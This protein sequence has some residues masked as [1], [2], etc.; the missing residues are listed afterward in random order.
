M[1]MERFKGKYRIPSAR[2]PNWNYAW[3]A[4]YFIT[5]CTKDRQPFFGVIQKGVMQLSSIGKIVEAEWL[6]TVALRSDMNIELGAY[7][8]MPNH[9]HAI[10]IIGENQFN[11]PR[12]DALRASRKDLPHASPKDLPRTSPTDNVGKRD[13][14]STSLHEYQNEFGPQHKNLSSMLGGFKAAVTKKARE[15]NSEF[16]W[17]TRFHDHII[18]N[19]EAYDRI[20]H[21]I[22]NNP[23][24]WDDDRYY[25]SS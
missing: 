8:V 16:G 1:G 24:N 2:R 20:Q 6:K 14:G 25:H 18:R 7:V 23:L 12:R 21:Y 13:A 4:A 22:L 15:F 11:T 19:S 9:F 3:Q 5:I 10:V 17:Q